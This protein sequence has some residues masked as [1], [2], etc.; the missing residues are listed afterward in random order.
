M[1][2][3]YPNK[4]G[5]E[6]KMFVSVKFMFPNPVFTSQIVAPHRERPREA[7]SSKT[8]SGRN[9][10]VRPSLAPQIIWNEAQWVGPERGWTCC[11][12]ACGPPRPACVARARS[13]WQQA[14]H[15]SPSSLLAPLGT[16]S[17]C[18]WSQPFHCMRNSSS[19]SMLLHLHFTN[20]PCMSWELDHSKKFSSSVGWWL[21]AGAG[22]FWEKSTAGWLLVAGLLW[23]KSTAGGW[24]ISQRTGRSSI[25]SSLQD[26]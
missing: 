24:L 14:Q 7:L 15:P 17:T 16:F 4:S 3:L 21:M 10:W 26:E 23:E 25:P 12:A 1:Q 9:R 6:K 18:P 22:F 2:K 13:H 19:P 8:R 20:N 11:W 5:L